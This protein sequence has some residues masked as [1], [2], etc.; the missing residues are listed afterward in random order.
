MR[1]SIRLTVALFLLTVSSRNYAQYA[2]VNPR[3]LPAQITAQELVVQTEPA[4]KDWQ[5][6]L[7]L[8][9]LLQDA[10][11]YRQSEDAYRHTIAILGEPDPLVV[12]D[13]FD[14][15][16]TMYVESGQLS[17]AEPV[18]RQALAIREHQHDNL[19]AGVSH[20]HLAMLLLGQNNLRAAQA[21][22]Q[23]A[24][25]LLVPE[26]LHL[27]A[28]SAATPEEKMTALIDLALVRCASGANRA[29]LPDLQWALLIAHANY[30]DNSLPVG[31][32][33]FLLG[34]ANWKS[35]N[36]KDAHRLMA[37]GVNQLA[38]VIG[39]GHPS[40]LKTLEQYRAFLLQTNQRDEA[41]RVLAEIERFGG[42]RNSFTVASG[43]VDTLGKK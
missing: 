1:S 25:S 23:S 18:E 2:D 35:G 31:Y 9:V 4:G 7:K 20:M 39:W 30:P 8:A 21:E 33:D 43:K 16:G 37:E 19:G 14:H 10:G 36:L 17:K 5:A 11:S 41:Q 6:W 27:S 32:V 29:A 28:T 38:T 34:Y 26:Y 13:V 15:M 12:A 42:S 24:V 22:A 3:T 40:Y